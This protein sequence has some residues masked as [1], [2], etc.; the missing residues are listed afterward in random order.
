MTGGGTYFLGVCL[1]PGEGSA[2]MSPEERDVRDTIWGSYLVFMCFGRKP[3]ARE[4]RVREA[5][6]GGRGPGEPATAMGGSC[7]C[8]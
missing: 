4:A 1:V 3:W 5:Q 8:C 2:G 7:R 6:P